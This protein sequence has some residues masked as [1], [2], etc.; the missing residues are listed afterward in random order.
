MVLPVLDASVF[1]CSGVFCV[2]PHLFQVKAG[3][4]SRGDKVQLATGVSWHTVNISPRFCK[5]AASLS[6][7]EGLH[8][9]LEGN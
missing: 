6:Q 2:P 3:I 7:H 1:R 4:K 8:P 9:S 5:S